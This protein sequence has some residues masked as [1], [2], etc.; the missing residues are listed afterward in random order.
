MRTHF[1]ETAEIE[2]SR[3]ATQD[4]MGMEAFDKVVDKIRRRGATRDIK[5]GPA[6]CQD[7]KEVIPTG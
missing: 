7:F 4:K 3:T 6:Y 5:I 2:A 1:R